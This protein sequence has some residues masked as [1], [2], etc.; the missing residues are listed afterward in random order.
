VVL[1]V[2]ELTEEAGLVTSEEVPAA[3]VAGP[4]GVTGGLRLADTR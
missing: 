4:E 3:R 2:D 1:L